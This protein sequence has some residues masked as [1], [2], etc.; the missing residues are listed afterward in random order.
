MVT[1]TYAS[2]L[3]TEFTPMRKLPPKAD[4]CVL[5][6]DI[7]SLKN[8]WLPLEFDGPILYVAGNHEYYG[9]KHEYHPLIK[10]REIFEFKGVRFACATLWTDLSNPMDYLVAKEGMNDFRYI[11][12]LKWNEEF[13]KDLE[14]LNT[15]NADVFITHHAPS[16]LSVPPEYRA[17]P[18]SKA[19][20]TDIFNPY[21]PYLDH[22]P[23]L[24]IHGHTH[25]KCDYIINNTRVVS[26]P[27]GYTD[28]TNFRW[29]IVN[30]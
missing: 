27:R 9:R 11:K 24:W 14:F 19:Y 16:I 18:L 22:E 12:K 15:S 17:A 6:G 20:Y 21:S 30:C 10:N 29:E 4:I 3:H 28:D 2:D 7:G 5:A 1:I 25:F 26:N 23:K 13:Q 8:P